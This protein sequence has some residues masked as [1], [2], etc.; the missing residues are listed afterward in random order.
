MIAFAVVVVSYS[1]VWI[2]G[3]FFILRRLHTIRKRT[4]KRIHDYDEQYVF[5]VFRKPWIV[6]A[7]LALVVYAISIAL[8]V[9]FLKP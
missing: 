4:E 9:L 6:T 5:P 8:I 7:I 3:I 1:L 2:V